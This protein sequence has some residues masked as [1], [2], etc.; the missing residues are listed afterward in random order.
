MIG[1][2][3][4]NWRLAAIGGAAGP[5]FLSPIRCSFILSPGKADAVAAIEEANR[6]A[7]RPP[8]LEDDVARCYRALAAAGCANRQVFPQPCGVIGDSLRDVE[9]KTRA[10][11]QRID[12]HFE[13]GIRK[14]L[15]WER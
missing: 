12:T 6:E 8:M 11:Q 15:C 5:H 1:F 3:F 14:G 10:D 7:D 4:A 9:G 2:L 13:R